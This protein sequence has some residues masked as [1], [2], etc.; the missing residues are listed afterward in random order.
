MKACVNEYRQVRG[1][2]AYRSMLKFKASRM[3]SRK[4]VL[5][6]VAPAVWVEA[7]VASN[8]RGRGVRPIKPLPQ[9]RCGDDQDMSAASGRPRDIRAG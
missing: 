3:H 9:K 1:A 6:V 8:H 2:K 7:L 4:T 5:P